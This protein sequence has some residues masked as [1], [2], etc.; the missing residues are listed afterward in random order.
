MLFFYFVLTMVITASCTNNH[1]VSKNNI[2]QI[3]KG[4]RAFIDDS[5]YTFDPDYAILST[6]IFPDSF[7]HEHYKRDT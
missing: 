2:L 3:P 1:L 4:I 7:R 5:L 6:D